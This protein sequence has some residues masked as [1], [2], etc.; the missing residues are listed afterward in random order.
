MGYQS[1]AKLL[2]SVKRMTKFIESKVHSSKQVLA[3]V[4]PSVRISPVLP[5]LAIVHVQPT[6][7]PSTTQPVQMP[8]LPDEPNH[9]MPDGDQA[10]E[11]PEPGT[12]ADILT[13]RKFFDMVEK[14][15][16][17]IFKPP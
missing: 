14:L 16:W 3:S 9:D 15:Q 13:R 5:N 17:D 6:T 1:P 8:C 4:L 10:Q 11:L 2:R 12:S 7:L